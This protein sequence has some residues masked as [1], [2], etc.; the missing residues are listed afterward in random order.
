LFGE[1]QEPEPISLLLGDT[2][3][4]ASIEIDMATKQP[5]GLALTHIPHIKDAAFFS[6]AI[7]EAYAQFSRGEE[8]TPLNTTPQEQVIMTPETTVVETPKPSFIDSVM[9]LFSGAKPEEL[10]AVEGALVQA[11]TGKTAREIQLE[12]ELE[13]HK[14]ELA[15]FSQSEA[16]KAREAAGSAAIAFADGLVEA[17][18]KV[19]DTPLV[20]GNDAYEKAVALFSMAAEFDASKPALAC[21]SDD[22]KAT[23]FNATEAVKAVFEALPK[24]TKNEEQAGGLNPEAVAVFEQNE[25]TTKDSAGNVVPVSRQNELLGLTP[26]GQA[27]VAKDETK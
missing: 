18:V 15:K 1:W 11:K 27:V 14:A 9:A 2:P 7:E 12:E 3:R 20:K 6:Q 16:D 10:D 21:F 4:K 19:G 17:S 23:D 24:H 8:V 22:F 25:T 13:Q 5:V 26:L